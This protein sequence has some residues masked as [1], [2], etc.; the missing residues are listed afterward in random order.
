M[1]LL[2][3]DQTVILN[4]EKVKEKGWCL[5]VNPKN[6]CWWHH[7]NEAGCRVYQIGPFVLEVFHQCW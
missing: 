6:W 3:A 1:K 7:S 2:S 5:S 4:G